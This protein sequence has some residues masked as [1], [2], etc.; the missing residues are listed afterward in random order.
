MRLKADES[1]SGYALFEP[2]PELENNP[3]YFEYYVHW[4]NEARRYVPCAGDDCPYCAV[5][6]APKTRAITAWYFPDNDKNDQFK[7][8]EFNYTTTQL[9]DD[10]AEDEDGIQGKKLRIKR[11]NDDGDYTVKTR[12]GPDNKPLTATAL[13]KV[14]A[15]FEEKFD[16]A[17]MQD[18]RLMAA[19]EAMRAQDALD[20]VDDDEDDEEE[21]TPKPRT[22]K[23]KAAAVEEDEDEDDE[24]EIEEDDEDEE[25][26]DEEDESEEE[27][28]E[29][30][31]EEADEDEDEDEDEESDEE[32]EDEDAEEIQGKFTVSRVANEEDGILNLVNADDERFKMFVAEDLEIDYDEVKKGVEVNLSAQADDEGDWIITEIKV[33]PKRRTTAKATTGT[34][35][36]R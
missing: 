19:L 11:L 14:M 27:D 30:E 25:D 31:E 36:R 17:E 32:D 1:F 21:P 29:D 3:G 16:L 9:L 2:N 15:E 26:E 35:R 28:E 12:T 18:K 23:A 8:F 7:L 4:D 33:A 5:N 6:D 13:K 20:D 34:R 24:D 10:E 22:G